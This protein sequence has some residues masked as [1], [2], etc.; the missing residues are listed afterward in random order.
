MEPRTEPMPLTAEDLDAA[1][2]E[3]LEREVVESARLAELPM[4]RRQ[5]DR[6]IRLLEELCTL[7]RR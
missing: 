3:D 1:V 5:G 7:V 6:L 4:S 2:S